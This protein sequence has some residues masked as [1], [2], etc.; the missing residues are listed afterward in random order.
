MRRN[1]A[2]IILLLTTNYPSSPLGG[3]NWVGSMGLQHLPNVTLEQSEKATQLAENGLA[4]QEKH[5]PKDDSSVLAVSCALA[6]VHWFNGAPKKEIG[7]LEKLKKL[8]TGRSVM[9]RLAL[10]AELGKCYSSAKE[11]GKAAENLEMGIDAV[12]NKLTKD[13]PI[14]IVVNT[15]VFA[16]HTS[17]LAHLF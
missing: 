12:G 1:Y 4:F 15:C 11:Y 9:E 17:L 3:F 7:R 2:I 5:L 14:L 6:K 8:G 16:F 10:L 13:D